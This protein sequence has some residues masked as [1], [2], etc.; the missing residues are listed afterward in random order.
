VRK[1]IPADQVDWELTVPFNRLGITSFMVNEGLV[2]LEEV[3]GNN[4]VLENI[5]IRV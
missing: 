3:C 4:G 1:E 5:Y 2:H